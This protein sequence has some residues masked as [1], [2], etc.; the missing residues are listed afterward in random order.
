MSDQ[1]DQEEFGILCSV[2]RTRMYA[3]IA[4][5]GEKVRCPDC[6]TNHSVTEKDAREFRQKQF[7]ANQPAAKPEQGLTS[8]DGLDDDDAYQLAPIEARPKPQ[9][10]STPNVPA[11]PETEYIRAPCPTCRWFYVGKSDSIGQPTTCPDC[12]TVFTIKPLARSKPKKRVVAYDPKIGIEE[13]PELPEQEDRSEALMEKAHDHRRKVDAEKPQPVKQPFTETIYSFP[14]MPRVIQA[15]LPL[16]IFLV[17]G[18]GAMAYG[19]SMQGKAQ[20]VG[21]FAF[22]FGLPFIIT[23]V[24]FVGFH[25]ITLL[26]TTANGF[27]QPVEWPRFDFGEWFSHALFFWF[28]VSVS[29]V[30]G[31]LVGLTIP[32]YGK[33]IAQGLS[34]L[35]FHPFVMLSMMDANSPVV[36]YTQF[37]GKTLSVAKGAWA[38]FY[39]ALLPSVIAVVGTAAAAVAVPRLGFDIIATF[40]AFIVFVIVGAIAMT[41]YFRLLG[42]LALVLGELPNQD[43]LDP[44]HD[45]DEEDVIELDR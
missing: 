36:P 33:W 4:Q 10:A 16:P 45:V 13:A 30:P 22:L 35:M 40:I 5:I 25:M 20:F 7:K 1:S 11:K 28:S 34:A 21:M 37:M 27:R 41:I 39:T 38:K 19:L 44:F 3:T 2:C 43:E 12:G 18:L 31:A 26:T 14:F 8:S 9:P 24:I 15:W 29:I 6:H 23:S 32:S 42:R 17:V